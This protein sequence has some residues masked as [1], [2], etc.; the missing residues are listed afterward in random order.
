MSLIVE[1]LKKSES[2]RR[3]GETP[4]ISTPA[5]WPSVGVKSNRR[6]VLVILFVQLLL[7]A[8]LATWWYSNKSST[9]DETK[10]KP[11]A[12]ASPM[13]DQIGKK[14]ATQAQLKNETTAADLAELQQFQRGELFTDNTKTVVQQQALL[15]PKLSSEALPRNNPTL[16]PP[17]TQSNDATTK[18]LPAMREDIVVEVAPVV[19]TPAVEASE[20]K[21]LSQIPYDF[22]LP[23]DVQAKL[24]KLKISMHVYAADAVKRFVI[25]NG[26]RYNEGAIV[27]EGLVLKEIRQQGLLMDFNGR[28]YL[29]NNP[30]P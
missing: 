12:A 30:R 5:M 28:S 18:S 7:L 1:A 11:I 15:K 14:N 10:Q 16:L 2:M 6:M 3:H 22:E 27:S 24:P 19:D 9:D 23:A 26:I 21:P 25:L 29:L 8:I 17:A 4:N 20:E 13:S